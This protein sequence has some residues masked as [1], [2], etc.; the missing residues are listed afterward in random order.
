MD[1][2]ALISKAVINHTKF[3]EC[4][5]HDTL[6]L[7]FLEARTI[8]DVCQDRTRAAVPSFKPCAEHKITQQILDQWVGCFVLKMIELID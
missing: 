2:S 7:I 1:C 8:S 3:S 6:T 4:H 5:P